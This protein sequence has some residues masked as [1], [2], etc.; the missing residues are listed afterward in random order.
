A[1]LL[2]VVALTARLREGWAFV[3]TTFAI[4]AVV[5]LLFGSLFPNVMPS[6]TDPAFDLTIENASSSP[7]TLKVMSWA[8][9]FMAPVVIGY[10]AWTYWVFRKRISTSHIPDSIGLSRGRS[11]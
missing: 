7:Y 11:S 3:F 10:Q 9:A 1:S 6:T 2:A 8:A 4:I 5:V